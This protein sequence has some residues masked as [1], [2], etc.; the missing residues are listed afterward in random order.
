MPGS[1]PRAL[2]HNPESSES[3]TIFD[4]AAVT[5]DLITAFSSKEEPFSSGYSI[6]KSLEDNILRS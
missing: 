1:P 2:T 4:N 5:D 6:P 3:D